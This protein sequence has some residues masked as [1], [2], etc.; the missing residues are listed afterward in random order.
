MA[1]GH[2]FFC[3]SVFAAFFVAIEGANILI[4]HHK[5]CGVFGDTISHFAIDS[6]YEHWE[7]QN[8]LASEEASYAG[9]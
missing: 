3:F 1:F 9:C 8:K 6:R 4:T 2:E 5:Q 7:P